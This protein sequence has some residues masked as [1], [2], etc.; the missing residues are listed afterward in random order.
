MARL[1]DIAHKQQ[2]NNHLWFLDNKLI[3]TTLKQKQTIPHDYNG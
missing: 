2:K 3:S 1:H